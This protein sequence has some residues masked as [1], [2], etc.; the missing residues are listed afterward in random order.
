M[1]RVTS[2]QEGCR[3]PQGCGESVATRRSIRLDRTRGRQPIETFNPQ[4][5][6]LNRLALCHR[7]S[8]SVDYNSRGLASQ[9]PDDANLIGI[10][11]RR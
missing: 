8:I 4:R 5:P 2:V 9:M 1:N 6:S 7:V 10:K 3:G 11:D